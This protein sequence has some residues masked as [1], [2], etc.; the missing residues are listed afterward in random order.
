MQPLTDKAEQYLNKRWKEQREYYSKKSARN[1]RWHQFLLVF[2]TVSALT[3]P[4]LLNLTEV[5]KLVPTILSVLVSVALA[6]DNVF[7]FG[8]NWRSF[9]QTLEALKRE[10]IYFEEGVGPY[11]DAQ[12]AFDLFVRTCEDLMQTEVKSYFESYKAKKRN[13]NAHL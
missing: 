6:L 12:T 2:S 11:A 9:R 10:R 3:V 5:P 1:K 8:E 4:V 13:G 7:H